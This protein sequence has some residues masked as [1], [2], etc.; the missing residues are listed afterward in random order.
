MN[1]FG[2]NVPKLNS[3]DRTRN[4]KAKTVYKT[5]VRS[6]QQLGGKHCKNYNGKVGFYRDGMLRN[7]RSFDKKDLLQK[8]YALCVDG[9]FSKK[10]RDDPNLE[11]DKGIG[12]GLQRGLFAC[13]KI[14]TL[15]NNAIKLT[16]GRDSI[17]NGYEGVSIQA[18]NGCNPMSGV[19][20][21]E[22][23]IEGFNADPSGLPPWNNVF[24]EIPREE[25]LESYP[26]IK[27]TDPSNNNNFFPL[28]TTILDPDNNL[29]G[30]DFCGEQIFGGEGPLKWLQ[31]A[32]VTDYTIVE[33]QMFDPTGTNYVG[34][35]LKAGDRAMDCNFQ[36]TTDKYNNPIRIPKQGDLAVA[37]LN[38]L[39]D[40]NSNIEQTENTTEL[41]LLN[42]YF[43]GEGGNAVPNAKNGLLETLSPAVNS[44]GP[45]NSTSGYEKDARELLEALRKMFITMSWPFQWFTGI[46][47]VDKVCCIDKKNKIWR[48][49][50]KSFWGNVV[51]PEDLPATEEITQV[52]GVAGGQR[53]TWR[54]GKRAPL[55]FE[56]KLGGVHKTVTSDVIAGLKNNKAIFPPTALIGG[57]FNQ[58]DVITGVGVPKLPTTPALPITVPYGQ[59]AT[60]PFAT[61]PA[62]CGDF[63][64]AAESAALSA[65][66]F[67]GGDEAGP[68]NAY[69]IPDDLVGKV[70][71]WGLFKYLFAGLLPN[72]MESGTLPGGGGIGF[73][74][75]NELSSFFKKLLGTSVAPIA[76]MGYEN[77]S[78]YR[79]G[80]ITDAF[81]S[82]CPASDQGIATRAMGINLSAASACG[83]DSWTVNQT[84]TDDFGL[85][86][87]KYLEA[88][89]YS[90][91]KA[92]GECGVRNLA[93]GNDTKQNY[94]VSYE[95]K[96]GNVN[97]AINQK[98][99]T[100]FTNQ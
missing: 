46:G 96:G 62:N 63:A 93:F 66:G 64:S 76:I 2:N 53:D 44:G 100:K 33:G 10:C 86:I 42:A 80:S 3:S 28:S 83:D 7:T 92:A 12:R 37:G 38:T 40:Y 84:K 60:A 71:R 82:P 59:Y 78:S 23:W 90:V 57:E 61:A 97:F 69:R 87:L 8:G 98:L 17:Y 91:Q 49:V 88:K 89:P 48:V 6:F 1:C 9:G 27:I 50:I 32:G 26:K 51:P 73:I 18:S 29:F 24:G 25:F 39:L 70:S 99:Y 43:Y 16:L 47:I 20:V 55:G 65:T 15:S 11:K 36:P 22:N 30:T 41:F 74:A 4:V 52:G 85:D 95:N 21:M 13:K 67:C 45:A 81:I 14:N 5:N 31:F 94:L 68:A 58:I 19:R 35:G 72:G 56:V 79:W 34:G 75:Q 54:G 77:T